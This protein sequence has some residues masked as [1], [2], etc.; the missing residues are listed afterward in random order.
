MHT[1]TKKFIILAIVLLLVIIIFSFEAILKRQKIVVIDKSIQKERSFNYNNLLDIACKSETSA[2]V[3]NIEQG[4]SF[5]VE[6]NSRITVTVNNAGKLTV[7]GTVDYIE[8]NTG[9]LIIA[10]R[11]NKILSHTG[12][13]KIEKGAIVTLV[14]ASIYAKIINAGTLYV[15]G[16]ISNI[17]GITNTGKIYFCQD[18][19]IEKESS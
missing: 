12:T 8:S 1:K 9:T 5:T 13:L 19:N 15:I 14:N 2:D 18:N 4:E 10:G 3:F 16:E 7:I 6:Q 11:V 17:N